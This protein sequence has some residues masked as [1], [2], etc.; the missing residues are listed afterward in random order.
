MSSPGSPSHG[1][2]GMSS[3]PHP[4]GYR[5]NTSSGLAPSKIADAILL[6]AEE[7]DAQLSS[8]TVKPYV[9][10][11]DNGVNVKSWLKMMTTQSQAKRC[12]MALYMDYPES[13]VDAAA[14]QLLMNSVSAYFQGVVA[15]LLLDL[16]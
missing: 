16:E 6:T 3:R 11:E 7:A 1:S 2:G 10:L 9:Q 13:A 4:T 8:Q 15:G 12:H 14:T 5:G